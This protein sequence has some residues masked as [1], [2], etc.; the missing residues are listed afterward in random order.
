MSRLGEALLDLD[1]PPVGTLCVFNAN[2]AATNPDQHRV[3]SGLAREDLFTVVLEQRHTDTTAYAD[4]VLPATMQPE[5]TDLH[6]AYGHLYVTWNEPAVE[7]PGEALPNT[8]VFRRL[9]GALGL[10][11]PRLHEPDVETARRLLDTP[12]F[13]RAGITVEELRRRGWARLPGSP[14]KT[15]SFADGG[16]PTASGKVELWSEALA[17][18]GH[19]PLVGYTPPHEAADERL[20]REYGLVLLAPAGRFFLNS[21]FAS[22]P[23]HRRRMGPPTVYLHP[24]DAARRGVEEG[25]Q[26]RVHNARGEFR[27]VAAVTDAARPGVAFTFKSYWPSLS[28]GGTNA[29]STTPERDAD[30]GGAP[31]FHDN[32][33]EVERIEPALASQTPRAAA[34]VPAR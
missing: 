17:E 21:T 24:D 26:I 22:L 19:D 25:D 4:I 13:R 27:A 7:P 5:H 12:S 18:A 6:Y 31:T 34:R 3:R 1:D 23:W 29:N 14:P 8:E 2:P 11:D 9:A 30:L 33:V 32:R 10:D 16:F 20:R 28:P 15:A